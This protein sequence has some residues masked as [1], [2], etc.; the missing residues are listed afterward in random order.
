M[1]PNSKFR[2]NNMPKMLI[3]HQ[4]LERIK[5][6]VDIA[7]KE[8]QWFCRCKKTTY[9]NTTIYLIYEMYIPEQYCSSAEVE[10]DPMMMVNFYL[11]FCIFHCV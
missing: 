5:H 3:S 11:Y 9:K 2:L 4:D 6:I 7:P 1:K 8:A 10:S